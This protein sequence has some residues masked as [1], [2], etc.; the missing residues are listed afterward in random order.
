MA[1]SGSSSFT[2]TTT[3][4]LSLSP[5]CGKGRSKQALHG[6]YRLPT[7]VIEAQIYLF[8]QTMAAFSDEKCQALVDK[9]ASERE[10]G[11]LSKSD[12]FMDWLRREP[13]E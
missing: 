1:S 5:K 2:T 12:T 9:F 13:R 6:H 10:D 4:S 7:Q 3:T 11:K 8:Q